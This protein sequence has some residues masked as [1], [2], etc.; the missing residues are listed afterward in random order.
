[1]ERV[2]A[3]LLAS[4]EPS[5][6]WIVR[7]G[8]L[9][10]DDDAEAREEIRASPRVRTLLAARGPDGRVDDP[11]Q[12]YSKWRG[13]HWILLA[14]AELGY[15]PGDEHLVPL[16]DQVLERWLTP[17]VF[18]DATTP[19][20]KGIL[21]VN[22]RHRRCAS[23]QGAALLAVTRLGLADE[24]AATL[25][26][27]LR[28]WQWPDGGW[29]CDKRAGARMSSV[30]ET[31]LPLRGLAAY[32]GATGDRAARAAARA[33]AEVLLDRRI[34]W[35]RST[36]APLS[37]RTTLLRYPLY[38]N[39]DVLGG[40]RG[41]AEAGLLADP[42]CTDALDFLESEQLPG[43]GWAADGRYWAP[44]GGTRLPRDRVDWGPVRAGVRN[45][46]VTAHA[47]AVLTAAGRLDAA[48][49]RRG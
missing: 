6:R 25:V 47:L 42:R 23:Q 45:E 18:R 9:G 17:A 15:P 1:V 28:H 29:N 8:V 30:A 43:G 32:A 35:R 27:R 22:G 31:L 38:W 44:A 4:D 41:V 19:T 3:E 14:L 36:G 48:L 46:W 10:E 24:R 33:A 13:A 20:G 26:E 37:R 12:P 5:V 40:L 2:V 21:V 39:Y 16:R 7:T 49:P 11:K 34:G